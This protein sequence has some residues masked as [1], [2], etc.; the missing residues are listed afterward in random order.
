MSKIIKITIVILAIMFVAGAFGYFRDDLWSLLPGTDTAARGGEQ[1]PQRPPA[2]VDVTTVRRGEIKVTTESVGTLQARE[3]VSLTSQVTGLVQAIH[4]TE[5]QRVEQG[6]MLMELDDAQEQAQLAEAVAVREEANRQYQRG[7]ELRGSGL[8]TPAK[9]DE[10]EAAYETAAA[11]VRVA[12]A[13][14]QNHSIK[15]PFSG[16]IGLRQISRGALL[17]PGTVIADLYTTDPL[18][19]SFGV[20]SAFLPQL[21]PGLTVIA[22][23]AGLNGKVF[24]GS[25][26]L[27]DTDIDPRT[28]NIKVEAELPNPEG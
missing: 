27:I 6:Q 18:D 7:L 14:L 10:L 4:F 8:I 17:T 28:H 13:R 19:L 24:Q 5:G 11:G 16:L 25:V 20:R 23:A 1:Q 21:K 9:L 26:S 2:P 15:A 3:Q 12:E 22:R